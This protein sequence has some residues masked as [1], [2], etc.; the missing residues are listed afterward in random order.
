MSN[1]WSGVLNTTTKKFLKGASD[2]TIRKRLLLA[3]L[4]SKGKISYNNSGTSVQ[5]QRKYKEHT[6]QSFG[7]GSSMDFSPLDSHVRLEVDWRAY[8]MTDMM[9]EKEKLMNRGNEALINRS[10]DIIES[11]AKDMDK[12]FPA[13]MYADGYAAGNDNRLIGF[14]SFTGVGTN[15]AADLVAQPSDTYGGLSTALAT[16]GGTWSSAGTA[17]NAAIA[18]DWPNP[19]GSSEYDFFSPIMVN[20]SSTSW[21]TSVTTWEGNCERALRQGLMWATVQGGIGGRTDLVL[22]SAPLFYGFKNHW[23][24]K[25]VINTPHKASQDLGFEDTL[26]FEGV[27]LAFDFDVPDANSAYGWNFDELE[28]MGQE[29]QLFNLK[30]PEEEFRTDSILYKIGFFGNLKFESPKAFCKWKNFS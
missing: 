15:V 17:P 2:G 3:M 14:D 16:K 25:V 8:K 22:M 4:K 18:T 29:D 6:L 1:E 13:E 11:L 19:T 10:A 27:G 26:N 20:W 23:A 30:G 12:K 28:L 21:G 24:S 5:W 7:Y 9:H